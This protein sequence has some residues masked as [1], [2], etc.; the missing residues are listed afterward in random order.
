MSKLLCRVNDTEYQ[1]L[2]E[3]TN[4]NLDKFTSKYFSYDFK[5]VY[6]NL[7]D[8][9]RLI[10]CTDDNNKRRLLYKEDIIA[11]MALI[12]D[13]DFI[14]FLTKEDKKIHKD[15]LTSR[16]FSDFHKDML[17]DRNRF[18]NDI[19]GWR[20]EIK[21]GDNYYDTI[22]TVLNQYIHYT[23]IFKDKI[24][25]KDI[26]D[27]ILSDE[28]M[29]KRYEEMEKELQ[30]GDA[31]FKKVQNDE[32]NYVVDKNGNKV[33]INDLDEYYEMNDLDDEVETNL[34]IDGLEHKK[35]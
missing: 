21:K 30:K 22:R 29:K 15:D 24:K 14:N 31:V 1:I 7:D 25:Y 23:N 5:G 11:F 20:K 6:K 33:K 28:D 26:I 9:K 13:Y 8:I 19:N 12:N 4:E 32:E 2:R 27:N 17:H 35:M 3:D 10:I 18:A 16:I 34:E